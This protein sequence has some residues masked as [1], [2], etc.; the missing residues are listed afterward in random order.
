MLLQFFAAGAHFI[1]RQDVAKETGEIFCIVG[2]I[3]S[4]RI[5][6]ACA[7]LVHKDQVVVLPDRLKNPAMGQFDQVCGR[8]AGAAVQRKDGIRRPACCLV[9][10]GPQ[11]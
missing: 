8:G 10:S 11:S 1:R 5:G 7:S 9:I 2:Y 4:E 3:T 6:A